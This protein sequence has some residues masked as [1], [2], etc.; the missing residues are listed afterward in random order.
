PEGSDDAPLAAV[1][2]ILARVRAEGDAAVRALT[3]EFDGCDLPDPRVPPERIAAALDGLP[4]D[5]R[6]ALEFA[7]DQIEAYHRTQV[8]PVVAGEVA[9]PERGGVRVR[10]LVRPVER[11]GCY[12][13]GGRAVYPSS[14]LMTAVP[15]R[16]AG[17]PEV[18]LC[19][20]PDRDGEVP[21]V[22]L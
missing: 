9:V 2:A 3:L 19:V 16:V 4:A 22:T 1:R 18:V 21:A 5:L 10:D 13:P 17:V 7:R 20:P 8:G 6:A 15:A 11:V 14:V 12:V